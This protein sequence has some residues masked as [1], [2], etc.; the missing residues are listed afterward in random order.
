MTA[1][2]VPIGRVPR[3]IAWRSEILWGSVWLGKEDPSNYARAKTSSAG[4]SQMIFTELLHGHAADVGQNYASN[5]TPEFDEKEVILWQLV[6]HI[7]GAD[8][9]R[10]DLTHRAFVD[11]R[12]GLKPRIVGAPL[13]V[14]DSKEPIEDRI[15]KLPPGVIAKEGTLA[16]GDLESI[17]PNITTIKQDGMVFPI[18][19]TFPKRDWLDLQLRV[20][21]PF[22]FKSP[23]KV[24][25][26]LSLVTKTELTE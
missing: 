1:F 19:F 17:T 9:A 21:E 22:A 15:S 7:H 18:A 10:E 25:I 14:L 8:D 5:W 26:A 3:S 2:N 24:S 12:V 11:L 16:I 23:M 13:W 20:D 6:A 4:Q